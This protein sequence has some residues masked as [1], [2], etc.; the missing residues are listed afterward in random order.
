MLPEKPWRS[1]AV[2]RLLLLVSL[3]YLLGALL[4]TSLAKSGAGQHFGN[5]K[6]VTFAL[7]TLV[8]Y[9]ATLFFIRAF[10]REHNIGWSQALGFFSPSRGRGL[11][12][13]ILVAVIVLPIA[14]ALTELS[15]LVLIHFHV[16][17][18]E[19]P[20]VQTLKSSVSWNQRILFGVIAILLAPLVEEIL[21]RGILYPTLKQKG[22][23]RLALWG[24]SLFFALTH[25]NVPTFVPLTFLAVILTLLYEE[26]S[27]LLT[28]IL[29]HSLFNAAN[30]YWLLKQQ[31][32]GFGK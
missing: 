9:L 23:R 5:P 27:T 16:Q 31:G 30:Y 15:T 10:F 14:H 26:T 25:S 24:T 32:L 18:P 22:Y 20:T 17:A 19:Q 29:T 11:V 3:S 28:P 1:E 4:A 13:S 6:F 7:V 8:F 21:F 12:L 2:I